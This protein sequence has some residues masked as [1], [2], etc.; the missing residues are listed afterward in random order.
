MEIE[1]LKGLLAAKERDY[2]LYYNQYQN[3]AKENENLKAKLLHVD[4][5]FTVSHIFNF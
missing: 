1:K 5:N 3:V 4:E 2:I